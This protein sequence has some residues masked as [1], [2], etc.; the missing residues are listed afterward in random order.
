MKGK[1]HLS[2]FGRAGFEHA[3]AG[4][5]SLKIIP[6]RHALADEAFRIARAGDEVAVAIGHSDQ[7]MAELLVLDLKVRDKL[8]R[9]DEADGQRLRPAGSA[10]KDQGD[11]RLCAVLARQH[12]GDGGPAGLADLLDDVRRQGRALGRNEE[13]NALVRACRRGHVKAGRHV[14]Q[15]SG[16]GMGDHAGAG[17]QQPQGIVSQRLARFPDRE[18]DH[19]GCRN[20]RDENEGA[21]PEAETES[22]WCLHEARSKRGTVSGTGGLLAADRPLSIC[23]WSHF[24][25]RRACAPL[26]NCS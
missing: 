5:E 12:V 18:A 13:G 8:G 3:L 19:G 24:L 25:S 2:A 16:N 21:K 11:L 22:G 9:G 4:A 1:D 20:Q 6:V 14:G 26:E 7:E 10:G 15:F 17:L 23:G